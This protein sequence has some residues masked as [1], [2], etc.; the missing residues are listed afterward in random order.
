LI[1][2]KITGYT[3]II[4]MLRKAN[5][6][7]AG[8]LKVVSLTGNTEDRITVIKKTIFTKISGAQPVVIFLAAVRHKGHT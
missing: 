1:F 2:E 4:D 8:S 6:I 3:A 7:T 5:V